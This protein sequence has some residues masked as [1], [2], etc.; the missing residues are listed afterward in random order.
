MSW[1]FD[2][3]EMETINDLFNIPMDGDELFTDENSGLPDYIIEYDHNQIS[4][5]EKKLIEMTEAIPD[6]QIKRDEFKKCLEQKK[7]NKLC[8][9]LTHARSDTF[10]KALYRLGE[11]LYAVYIYA[12]NS[13]YEELVQRLD[14]LK[15][16]DLYLYENFIQ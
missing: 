12:L 9:E 15:G 16:Y 2:F 4:D 6:P 1:D 8:T 7:F 13:G 3:D 14:D 10:I 5:Y 11:V